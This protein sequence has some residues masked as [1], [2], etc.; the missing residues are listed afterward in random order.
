[1]AGRSVRL[2]EIV[3][4][5]GWAE[6]KAEARRLIAQGAIHVGR[7]AHPNA[8]SWGPEVWDL[9]ARTIPSVVV[10]RE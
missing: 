4:R 9:L 7:D 1:M 2:D 6:T 3:V 8:P 10:E 5:V